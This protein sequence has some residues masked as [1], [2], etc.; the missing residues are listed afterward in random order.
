[1][2]NVFKIGYLHFFFFIIYYKF[3]GVRT[4][5]EYLMFRYKHLTFLSFKVTKSKFS[6][7]AHERFLSF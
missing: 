3:K 1:M 7:E 2:R 5:D 6:S 4:T